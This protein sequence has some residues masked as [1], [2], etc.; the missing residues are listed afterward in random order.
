MSASWWP[1]SEMA[2]HRAG[3]DPHGARFEPRRSVGLL[4]RLD[5]DATAALLLLRDPHAEHPVVELC[6]DVLGLDLARE[7][8]AVIESPDAPRATADDALALALLQ[9]AGDRQLVS[10]E[11]DVHV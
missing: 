11:L 4:R 7:H 5:L 6:L 8:H 1:V 2:G 9:L 10:D 3:P